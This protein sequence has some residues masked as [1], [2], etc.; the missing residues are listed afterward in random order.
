MAADVLASPKL[1]ATNDVLTECS[2]TL[3]SSGVLEA[4]KLLNART[5]FRFTGVYQAEPPNLRNVSL[6]DRENPTLNVSGEVKLIDDSYCTFPCATAQ[7]FST[8]NSAT[9]RRLLDHA[10]RNAVIS[11]VGVPIRLGSGHVW[12]TLCHYDVRPR[13]LSPG[14]LDVLETVAPLF[15]EW[16]AQPF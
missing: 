9:D 2:R 16:L 15:K 1:G 8:E 13:S 5:R 11:Y 7:P 6:F 12:G 3:T 10:A 14:E 4:L